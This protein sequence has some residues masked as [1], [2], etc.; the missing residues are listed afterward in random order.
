M[1]QATYNSE[2]PLTELVDRLR[3]QGRSGVELVHCLAALVLLRWADF[4][5]AEAEAVALFEDE[6]YTPL[7]PTAY[8]WRKWCILAPGERASFLRQQLPRAVSLIRDRHDL[9]APMIERAAAVFADTEALPTEVLSELVEWLARQRFE[10]PSDRLQLRMKFDGLLDRFDGREVGEFRTPKEICDLLVALVKPKAGESVYDPC[11]GTG[12]ILSAAYDHLRAGR[13]RGFSR[14]GDAGLLISGRD[15]HPQACLLATAR[16]VLSGATTARLENGNSLEQEPVA[17]PARRGYDL[18]LCNPPWGLRISRTGRSHYPVATDDATGLFVQHV[19]GQLKPEGRAAVVVPQGFLFQKSRL[20]EVRRWLLSQHRLEA[21]VSLA[22][23]AFQP[24]T[25]MKAAVLLLRRNSGGTR[26]VRMVDAAPCF[27]KGRGKASR[28][29][30]GS[31]RMLLETLTTELPSEQH[32][33]LDADQLRKLDYD[34]TPVRR[35]KAGL[36]HELESLGAKVEIMPLAE[37]CRISSG[38]SARSEFLQD[39]SGSENAVPYLRIGDLQSGQINRGKSWITDLQAAGISAKSKLRAGDVL[40]SRS[41]SIGKTG[42]VCNGAVGGIA[43]NGFFVLSPE[44]GRLDPHYLVAWLSCSACAEWLGAR[45][46]GSTIP[47]LRKE[48]LA[49]TPVPILPLPAQQRVVEELGISGLDFLRLLSRILNESDINPVLSWLKSSESCAND[50]AS[51]PPATYLDQLRKHIFTDESKALLEGWNAGNDSA[52]DSKWIAAF[53]EACGLLDQVDDV[54][55][56]APLASVLERAASVLNDASASLLK[57]SHGFNS[58]ESIAG[59]LT[60][61]CAELLRW[62]VDAM[63]GEI[64]IVISPVTKE[65]SLGAVQ[66]VR[67]RISNPGKA[68][69]SGIIIRCEALGFSV[70]QGFLEQG[71]MKEVVQEVEVPQASEPLEF[72]FQWEATDLRGSRHE[73]AET[74]GFRFV[75]ASRVEEPTATLGPSPYFHGPPVG[76]DRDD[77]FFGRELLL[78]QIKSQ[79]LSGNTVLLEGNRRSGKSSILRHLEGLDAIPGWI[80]VFADFQSAE[81]DKAKAGMPSESVWRSLAAA[82]I[83]G[84]VRLGVPLPLPNGK[85][86]KPGTLL[87]YREACRQGIGTEAPWEDFLEFFQ[88]LLQLLEQRGLGLVLMIDEFDK[89]Q[90]GIDNGVTSPQIPENIRYLIQ[91]HPRFVA[92]M[93]G[94]R[95]MQRLRQEYWS[96]LYGLGNRIGV[97]ALEEEAARKLVTEPVMGRL[98]Y[99]AEAVRLILHLTARQPFL[100][101]YLCNRVF[102]MAA[103]KRV[104][105]VTR[106]MV[107][108]SA[109]GFVRD[110][111]HFASIWDYAESDRC[112]L[113]TL[114]CHQLS[115]EPDPVTFG[116][117][118]DRLHRDGVQISDAQL[119][120]DLVS[121]RELELIEFSGTNKGGHYTLTVPLMGQWLDDQQEYA[122]LLAKAIFEQEQKI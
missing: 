103:E 19:L 27:E 100:I 48:L 49:E 72:H 8:H 69:A 87:G 21:V 13:E 31:L 96:A 22:D 78:D 84:L 50:L 116:V 119:E 79:I 91:N 74:L 43:S 82:L 90:E 61:K 108:E 85:V 60:G 28:L 67:L 51:K 5:D 17:E 40:V 95:R 44:Q 110:N 18:V 63:L 109:V 111:E 38:V 76:P 14:S 32:W 83:S 64:D 30:A 46:H 68:P 39:Q 73:G 23:G 52:A 112:R 114:L 101:Q 29:K 56:G 57:G 118:K 70:R 65:L 58:M 104:Q 99:T 2:A 106:S 54:P 16:M 92:V 120:S 25:G 93:T 86:L 62:A 88:T 77:V 81:G 9:V 4:V 115:A 94:S 34:L 26:K 113:I 97:T 89:L 35:E 24:F 53:C 121:L 20:G 3:R 6:D 66:E 42:V 7:I 102:G 122:P 71:A 11:C 98:N 59:R 10:T 33:D 55:A 75:Q 47:S 12:G 107:E 45:S 80:A 1:K 105:A 37:V 117:L 41:G 36:H 15:I